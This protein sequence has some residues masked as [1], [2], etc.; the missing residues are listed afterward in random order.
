MNNLTITFDD[1]ESINLNTDF[2]NALLTDVSE[3]RPGGTDYCFQTE[4]ILHEPDKVV[5]FACNFNIPLDHCKNITHNKL[6]KK[7]GTLRPVVQKVYTKDLLKPFQWATMKELLTKWMNNLN[8]QGWHISKTKI[9]GEF[10][11]N[12]LIHA[13]GLVYIVSSRAYSIGISAIISKEWIKITK[14]SMNSLSKMN[15]QGKYDY[16]FAACNDVNAFLKYASKGPGLQ[17]GVCETNITQ[18]ELR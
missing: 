17:A 13:H 10:T 11:S 12:G 6:S 15:V 8:K 16:A 2:R 9:Y 4:N 18:K 1:M 14:G 7:T 3:N 5:P